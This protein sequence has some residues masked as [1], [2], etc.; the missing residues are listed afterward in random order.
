MGYHTLVGVVNAKNGQNRPRLFFVGFDD[1]VQFQAFKWPAAAELPLTS[2]LDS[3][4]S[5]SN[6][7]ALASPRQTVRRRNLQL[8][9]AKAR[10][11]NVRSAGGFVFFDIGASPSRPRVSHNR[12][13]CLLASGGGRLYVLNV[14]SLQVRKLSNTELGRLQGW[15]VQA[16]ADMVGILGERGFQHAMGNAISGSVMVCVLSNVLD[17]F[18]VRHNP[19]S[20]ELLNV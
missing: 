17:A 6:A 11:K 2:W 14:T 10:M 13:P 7:D 1:V 16:T 5:W 19:A 9:H 15:S 20:R 18:G 4:P 12:V 3:N 8:A